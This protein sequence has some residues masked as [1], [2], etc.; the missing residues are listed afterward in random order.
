MI[1]QSLQY[2]ESIDLKTDGTTP[3]LYTASFS[4]KAIAYYCGS[5]RPTQS[6]HRREE[7]VCFACDNNDVNLVYNVQKFTHN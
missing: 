5:I 6:A 4:F 1:R 7:P 3:E 2:W